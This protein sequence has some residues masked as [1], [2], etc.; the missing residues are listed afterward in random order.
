MNAVNVHGGGD[1][2]ARIS[3]SVGL[4]TEYGPEVGTETLSG[5]LGVVL[6][7]GM[8]PRSSSHGFR[9]TACA[10]AVRDLAK[11]RLCNEESE[12]FLVIMTLRKLFRFSIGSG[13]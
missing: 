3:C 7:G 12:S 9:L 2:F 10:L 11:E 5:C 13:L 6:S 1:A 4:R 8:L